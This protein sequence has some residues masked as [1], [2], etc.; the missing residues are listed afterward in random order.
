MLRRPRRWVIPAVGAFTPL[1]LLVV[2]GSAFVMR[3]LVAFRLVITT[4]ALLSGVFLNS[5]VLVQL[6]RVFRGRWPAH[7]LARDDVQEVLVAMG[8]AVVL[9]ASLLTAYFCYKGLENP[10]RL[11]N[12]EIFVSACIALLG[13]LILNAVLSRRTA[14]P[15]PQ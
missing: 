5:W 10:A 2:D 11:P 9:I 8:V 3:H 13:P 6:Y 12:W 14:V 15:G 7:R 4:M 1:G